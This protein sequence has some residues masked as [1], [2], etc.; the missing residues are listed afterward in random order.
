[1]CVSEKIKR[2]FRTSLF[3]LFALLAYGCRTT[4]TVQIFDDYKEKVTIAAPELAADE[5]EAYIFFRL[6]NPCYSS[7][8]NVTNLLKFGIST[9]NTIDIF[10]S[11]AAM[12]FD[13]ND[14]FYGVT[15]GGKQQLKL[16]IC[17][18]LQTIPI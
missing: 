1:M 5:D 17:T 11:H 7:P 2:V 15:L 13:L 4:R 14:N 18:D 9:T 3:A 12:G 8:L 10:V 16:E 6:Y